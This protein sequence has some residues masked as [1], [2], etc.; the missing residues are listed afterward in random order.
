MQ[1]RQL[2]ARL[3]VQRGAGRPDLVSER[4]T[5]PK[6]KRFSDSD[7]SPTLIEFDEHCQVD[8][9]FLLAIGAIAEYEPKKVK[10]GEA[11][12]PK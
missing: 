1:Y 2:S 4:P 12:E 5:D 3:R 8:I 6:T 10:H 7:E 9:P 11:L